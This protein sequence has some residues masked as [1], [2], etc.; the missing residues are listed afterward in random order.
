MAGHPPQEQGH[1]GE[2]V[3]GCSFPGAAT[4]EPREGVKELEGRLPVP[5][6][7]P[8][9]SLPQRSRVGFRVRRGEARRSDARG[10]QQPEPRVELH[11][12]EARREARFGADGTRGR[13]VAVLLSLAAAGAAVQRG[14][15][16][17]DGGFAG[18]GEAEEAGGQGAFGEF[19]AG[20]VGFEE[21]EERGEGGVGVYFLLGGGAV[22]D[23]GE[24]EGAVRFA[25]VAEPSD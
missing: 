2:R 19:G 22:G 14:E 10:I 11:A 17:D 25:E 4:G 9:V 3:R 20:G 24:G 8:S 6:P 15:G 13:G 18:V 23:G 12:P 21:G 7:V 16:V 1:G 5:V